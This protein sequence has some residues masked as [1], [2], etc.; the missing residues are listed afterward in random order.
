[1]TQTWHDLLFA[2]WPVDPEVLRTK[3][4]VPFELDLFDEH[5]WLSL[6]PFDMSNVAARFTP[7]LPG[8]W[9]FPE[10]NV[11]TYVRVGGKPGVFFFSLDAANRPAVAAAQI[12]LNLPYKNAAIALTHD[13]AGVRYEVRRRDGAARLSATYAPIGSVFVAAPGTVEHFL[14]ERYCLYHVNRRGQPYRM[15]IH[16]PPWQLQR[17]EWRA[18]SNTMFEADG[19]AT[20]PGLPTL[21]FSRRQDV[22]VWPRQY[23]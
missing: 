17:A 14:T 4:P 12:F 10:V 5:A 1:M 11:R 15:D 3:I 20:P 2:N 18:Q 6:V 13:D 23:L 7:S 22:V 9:T 8:L 19:L 21:Y 16:H